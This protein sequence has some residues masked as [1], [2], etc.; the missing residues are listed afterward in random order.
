M[1]SMLGMHTEL[2]WGNLVEEQEG[3]I[4]KKWQNYIKLWNRLWGS[5]VTGTGWG[6]CQMAIFDISSVKPSGSTTSK[7]TL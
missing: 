5:E 7:L 2:Q 3:R 6:L 1:W 4:R